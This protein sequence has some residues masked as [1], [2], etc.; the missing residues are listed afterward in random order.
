MIFPIASGAAFLAAGLTVLTISSAL[1]ATHPLSVSK[2]GRRL[3]QANGKPFLY[4]ADTA[5]ELFHRLDR[6]EAEVYLKDR[7]KKGFTAVQAVVLAELEGIREPN[8]YGEFPLIDNDPHKPN[9][10]YFEHVDWI[11]SKAESLG[12]TIA[13][14]PTWGDKWHAT[15]SN[16]GPVLFKTEADIAAFGAFVGKRYKDRAVIFVL[17]GDRN[18][19][20]KAELGLMRAL[21][22]AIKDA[23]PKNLI[24]YHPR[25][26]GRSSDVLHKEAWLDFNM[27]Q[28]SHTGRDYDSAVN[29]DHDR[30]LR[31]LIVFRFTTLVS[32]VECDSSSRRE[33]DLDV[34]TMRSSLLC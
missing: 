5:W 25:G 4:L 24:S 2:D 34:A 13:M 32:L 11:L 15:H 20:T 27:V 1:A 19:D 7:A 21:A 16:P 31:R 12:L 26:P 10:K 23:A 9:P 29:I 33:M 28:S 6:E 30:N 18:V 14:L 8:A 17:G 22:K 3:M